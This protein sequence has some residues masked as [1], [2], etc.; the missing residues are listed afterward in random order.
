MG[1]T[2]SL[3]EG[4]GSKRARGERLGM[5]RQAITIQ[6]LMIL[7][8]LLL[9]TL[10]LGAQPKSAA[11]QVFDEISQIRP[12]SVLFV[13]S[14]GQAVVVTQNEE[15]IEK[16]FKGGM[17]GRLFLLGRKG[18]VIE[19][20]RAGDKWSVVR[21]DGSRVAIDD[22]P[23][24]KQFAELLEKGRTHG[25]FTACKSNLKNIATA[26]EMYSTDWRGKFPPVESGLSLLTPNYLRTIPTC[27]AAGTATYSYA[28]GPD[29]E[30]N[31]YGYQDYYELRCVGGNHTSV[32]AEGDLPVYTA[33]VGLISSNKF[34]TAAIEDAK[35]QRQ[36]RAKK[37]KAEK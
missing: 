4:P 3:L 10:W 32:G 14:E 16:F 29:A 17:T 1:S 20:S 25:K 26:M 6:S 27:P 15:F 18:V 31:G 2:P 21:V 36:E 9:T 28:G 19:L 7:T 34:L 23:F 33:I 5:S 13:P 30:L 22:E 35:R 11:E 37:T 12:K 24:A 8:M